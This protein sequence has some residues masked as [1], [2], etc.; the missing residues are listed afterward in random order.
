MR[1]LFVED[2]EDDS[3]LVERVL[4]LSGLSAT[5][6][7]TRAKDLGTAL[8]KLEAEEFGLVLFDM[9]L[10]DSFGITGIERISAKAP[11][12]A[13]IVLTGNED[14]SVGVEAVRHGAQD[15]L[16]KNDLKPDTLRRVVSYA[17]ERKQTERELRRARKTAEEASRAKS[18][19]LANMSHEIRT[20]MNGVVGITGLLLSSNLD[21]KQ[22]EFAELIKKSADTLLAL[23]NDIL[24]FS[25]IEAGK[26]ELD[27][28]AFY[29]R[30]SVGDTV[31][32]LAVEAGE[33]QLE[34][35]FHVLPD[36]P[37]FLVGDLGRLRQILVN[38]VGNAIKFT[39]QG[40]IVVRVEEESHND[41]ATTLKFSVRDTGIGIE[42]DKQEKIFDA[43]AQADNST[44][45]EYG[46]T[47]LGLAICAKL[48]ALMDGKIRVESVPGE[49]STFQ[50][51][52]TFGLDYG[53]HEAWDDAPP[54]LHDFPM[55]VVDDNATNRLILEEILL[56]WGIKP[57]LAAGG[58][59]GL[60]MIENSADEF[61]LILLDQLMPGMDGIEFAKLVRERA[62]GKPPRFIMLSSAGSSVTPEDLRSLGIVRC[63]TKPAK[64]AD[65]LDAITDSLGIATRNPEPP[66]N[67][68]RIQQSSPVGAL[69]VLIAEDGQVN[70][71][72]A[73]NMLT[74]RGHL[75]E[76]VVNGVEAVAAVKRGRLD[77]VLMDVQMP[78]LNGYEATSTI[79]EFEKVTGAHIP[80]IA[81]TANAMKG[82]REKCLEAG[83]DAYV[84]KPI[85][86]E[87]LIAVLEGF[88]GG[89][90]TIQSLPI[91]HVSTNDALPVFDSRKFRDTLRDEALMATVIDLFED[92]AT[93]LLA[94]LDDAIETE[95]AN[96][97][98]EAAHAI[99]GAMGSCAASAAFEV[100]HK[101]NDASGRGDL[102]SARALR[103]D[104]D[105]EV[106]RAKLALAEFRASLP[107]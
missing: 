99:K 7:T 89:D 39:R 52:A 73:E 75:V 33:K 96:A 25:K 82:D 87:E 32:S 2:D 71:V 104:L 50:F 59:E 1:I 60:A 43:F 65:L 101:L 29:L 31:Q 102:S 88:F 56:S 74:D 5:S 35:A 64:P 13:I 76:I 69:R 86:P 78:Q 46:G 28:H 95:D 90:T 92:E 62:D 10:P 40:E 4:R 42:P 8:Q 54:S 72:V 14:E 34:L 53:L 77:A 58:P 27:P 49:G 98:H 66:E 67:R 91:Q 6:T 37:D 47:G 19:F 36:V 22:K 26:L 93:T 55:L 80:I 20:P 30:D 12:V 44:T 15:F 97:V 105:R 21:A 16:T 3:M 9:G 61:R 18:E 24:D 79:R 84:S 68:T 85:D 17:V 70:R 103:E 57:V 51:T 106:Q 23:L 94:A 38:L 83:M 63:L 41:D 48:I 107:S 45:R 100:A 81:M 11:D